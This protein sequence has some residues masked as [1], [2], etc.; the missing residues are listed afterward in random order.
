MRCPA[1]VQCS[2]CCWARVSRSLS[3]LV[4]PEFKGGSGCTKRGK[5]LYTILLLHQEPDYWARAGAGAG[6]VRKMAGS[7]T[8]GTLYPYLNWNLREYLEAESP[9]KYKKKS[10][11]FEQIA[12]IFP[13]CGRSDAYSVTH[14]HLLNKFSLFFLQMKGCEFPLMNT[15]TH[16]TILVIPTWQKLW[17]L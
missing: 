17:R 10:S 2:Q 9:P 8:L 15:L 6:A 12:N 5:I 11:T 14:Q 13:L 3:F 1:L 7:T 4:E 16:S